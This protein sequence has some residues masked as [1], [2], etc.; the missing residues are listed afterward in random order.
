MQINEMTTTVISILIITSVTGSSSSLVFAQ[1][2]SETDLDSLTF[3]NSSEVLVDVTSTNSSEVQGPL[4]PSTPSQQ[5][6]QGPL[7]PSTPSQQQP[8]GPLSPPQ[9]NRS[10]N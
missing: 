5:Q 3:T 8:Q 10:S 9:F 4:S 6:P 1:N 2:E 7:S